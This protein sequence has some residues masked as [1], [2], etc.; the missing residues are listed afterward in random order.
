M[1]TH[2][3]LELP[4][5]F[6]SSEYTEITAHVAE[7]A[8]PPEKG[9]RFIRDTRLS[10]FALRITD[11]GAKSWIIEARVKGQRNA[12]RRTLGRYPG[13]SVVQARRLAIQALGEFA[14]GTDRLAVERQE[15]AQNITL[16]VAFKDYMK[17]RPLKDQSRIRY[18]SVYQKTFSDWGNKQLTQ[19]TR[20]MV[21]NRHKLATKERGPA[22][23]NLSMRILRAIFNYAAGR[24][25]GADGEP[26]VTDNPTKRLNAV[27]AWNKVERRRRTIKP[28]Q[29]A[30]WYAGLDKLR[31]K[32]IAKY[33]GSHITADFLEFTLLTG[34]RKMEGLR[35]RWQ[36]V[37]LKGRR[38]LLPD[39]KNHQIHELPLSDRLIEILES[40]QRYR[41]ERVP[42]DSLA[43]EFVFPGE[44][45]SGHFVRPDLGIKEVVKHAGIEFSPHDLRRTFATTAEALDL[46]MS[47]IKRLLNHMTG[48]ADVTGGYILIDVERLRVPMQKITDSILGAAGRR[49][50]QG[51]NVVKLPLA[52]QA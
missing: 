14:E 39:T 28:H 8:Q 29:L 10:G 18:E 52:K 50:D 7:T 48:A 24:Y 21:E 46:P 44:G 37:D 16:D 43:Y 51:A 11:K 45:S 49:H 41:Q 2:D 38:F 30:D 12:K 9:Q 47:S 27:R 15:Q 17:A 20:T 31:E 34:C 35:L 4:E 3:D 6:K 42:S 40:R 19:I 33:P 1:I 36:D 23:A 26:V 32:D 13:V 22:A 5:G 25:E